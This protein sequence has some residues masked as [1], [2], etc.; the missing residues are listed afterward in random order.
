MVA[1]I[2][3][4]G[5]VLTVVNAGTHYQFLNAAYSNVQDLEETQRV[6]AIGD[7]RGFWQRIASEFLPILAIVYLLLAVV[8]CRDDMFVVL[9]GGLVLLAGWV[10]GGGLALLCTYYILHWLDA[11]VYLDLEIGSIRTAIAWAA[12]TL[13]YYV[14]YFIAKK[15]KAAAV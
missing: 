7:V 8:L 5:A 10:V 13:V 9:K 2:F 1:A 11:D 14:V 3:I 4:T 12:V 15:K 6:Q